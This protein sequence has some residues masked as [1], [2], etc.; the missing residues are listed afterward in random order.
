MEGSSGMSSII[1]ISRDDTSISGTTS[2]K[3]TGPLPGSRWEKIWAAMAVSAVM[4]WA[5]QR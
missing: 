5:I 4:A 3:I 2:Q 1:S